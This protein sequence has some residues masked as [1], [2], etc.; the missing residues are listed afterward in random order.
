MKLGD[1][2]NTQASKLGLQNDPALIALL[3]NSELANKEIDDKFANPMNEGLMSFESAKNNYNLKSHFSAQVLNSVDAKLLENMDKFD[4]DEETLSKI[5]E[6]KNS[7]NKIQL[8]K[9]AIG[10]SMEKLKTTGDTDGKTKRAEMEKQINELNN[11]LFNLKETHGKE[12]ADWELKYNNEIKDFLFT[13]YLASKNYANKEYSI[14]ENSAFAR[15]LIEKA[16]REENAVIVKDGDKLALRNGVSPD[17]EFYDK[18]NKKISFNDFSDKILASKKVLTV[19]APSEGIKPS[20]TTPQT[21][22]TKILSGD[23]TT[24]FNAAIQQSLGDLK[25]E[26]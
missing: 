18:D 16:L 12:K 3:S 22:E 23:K 4:L 25:Q 7:Y 14:E 11:Q 9:D 5:K 8:A 13:N 2:L 1:F 21:V 20:N 10:A 26:Q 15:M 6:E 19:S 24:M 17:L